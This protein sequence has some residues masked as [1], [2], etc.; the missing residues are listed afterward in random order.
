[1][2]FVAVINSLNRRN[3]LVPA[4]ESLVRAVDPKVFEY[5]VVVFEAGSTDGSREWLA[6]FAGQHPEVRLEVVEATGQGD[7]SFAAGVNAGCEFA[8]KAFPEV[9]FLFLYETDNWISS[10]D[11][12]IAAMRLLREE[13]R[14]AAVGFTVRRHSGRFCG[15]GGAFP[16]VLSFVLGPHLC[17]RLGLPRCKVRKRATHGIRWF[18]ADVVFTSPLLIRAPV[19]RSSG[20]FDAGQFPF[21]DSDFD[22]AWNVARDGRLL[23]VIE[24]DAVVHDNLEVSSGWSSMRVIDFHRSRF[25]LLRKHRGRG[26]IA[27]IPLLFLRHLS[28]YAIL[29]GLVLLGRRPKLSLKKR[30]VL[31][32][33]VWAGYESA[34]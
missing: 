1:M 6:G 20:G 4:L 27:A 2:R 15:W 21:S 19:W 28:E 30:H 23:G 29:T 12:L 3:L 26:V 13:P 7:S 5:A 14:L 33:S 8:L 18:T 16:T 17:M 31:L 34:A 32:K 24:T 22:W 9:E 10:P 11:P 25:R